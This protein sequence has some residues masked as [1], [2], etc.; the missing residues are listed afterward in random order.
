MMDRR[1]DGRMGVSLSL[2]IIIA[3]YNAREI[4]ADCL[5]SIY[6]NPPSEPYEIIVVDDASVDATSEM[7]RNRFPDV[8]LFTNATNR[9][10]ASS[11]N[12]A[13]KHA[14]GEYLYLLN[15]DTIMLP[16]AL[17]DMLGFLR[18]HP[19]VGVVGS[20]LL[21]ED[22]TIQWSVKTL[23]NMGSALFGARSII[24]RLFPN[25][26]FSRKHL[27]HF[28][29]DLSE[30]FIAGYVSSASMMIPSD[31]V[32]KV[33]GLDERFSYHVDADYCKRITNERYQCF[34]LPSSA[35]VHLNHKGG[36]M[37][38][39]K[40]RFLSV[41]EFHRGSQLFFQKHIRN[42]AWSLANI[43]VPVALLFRFLLSV[44]AQ[45]LAELRQIAHTCLW[46]LLVRR[47]SVPP[48]EPHHQKHFS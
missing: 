16:S 29:H 4:L 7:V 14:R 18:Q 31:V 24:T 36:T 10:Y 26:R 21:N 37:V 17:D 39:W 23:P 15:N 47:S 25:N 48:N 22:G 6:Q 30:P 11:I 12:L 28:D 42:T 43:I 1:P 35:V 34:Y 45:A 32:R 19:N 3:T 2:S 38:N 33:G 41:V 13:L 8:R 40:R 44:I 27:L 5:T 9:H 46:H 20:K